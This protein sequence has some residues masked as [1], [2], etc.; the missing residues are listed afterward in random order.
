MN[1]LPEQY[2]AEQFTQFYI[3]H[4]FMNYIESNKPPCPI[5]DFCVANTNH[6][7][8]RKDCLH[9]PLSSLDEEELCPFKAF[10]KLY[11]L[12]KVKF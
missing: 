2:R 10:I 12:S 7:F 4:Q 3:L 5:Y 8:D 9:D 6:K 1:L 11:G